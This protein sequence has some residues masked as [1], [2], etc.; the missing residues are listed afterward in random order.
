MIG[1]SG[2]DWSDEVLRTV[3]WTAGTFAITAVVFLCVVALLIRF[4]G[5]GRQFWRISGR[6][7]TGPS[8]W[9]AWGLLAANMVTAIFSVR[10]QLLLTYQGNDMYTAM[11]HVFQALADHRPEM[12]A[13]SETQ[14]WKSMVV[15]AVLATVLVLQQLL[16]IWV[17]QLFQVNW[18][19]WLTDLMAGDWLTDRAFYRNRFIDSTID[20][21]DQRIQQD[22]SEFVSGSHGLAFGGSVGGNSIGSGGAVGAGVALATFAP[23]LWD[24]SA[25]LTVLGVTIPRALF[26]LAF[27]FILFGTVVAFRVG[28]PLTQ[29][30]FALQRRTADFRY[31]LV[32]L[33]DNAESIAFY[34]GEQT[35]RRNLFDRFGAMIRSYWR[36]IYRA[37]TFTGWNLTVSQVAVVF[38]FLLL[39]PLVASGKMTL[40]QITQ[41]SSAFGQVN[42]AIS[43][44]RNSYDAFTY[45][46]STLVRLD[47]LNLADEQS[48]DLPTVDIVPT[49]ADLELR[50]VG[51]AKPDGSALIT[52]LDLRLSPGDA[53]VVK[54]PSGSGKTTLLRSV[55]GLWPFASGT[56]YR[57]VG[58]DVLF[59]SQFPYLPLGDV[60]TA[61]AYPAQPSFDDDALRAVLDTV[62]LAH[63]DDRI[64]DERDWAAILSPGERQRIA[65]ARILLNRPKLVFLDEA[66]SAMDEGLEYALYHL[67]RTETPDTIL[68]SVAHRST[69]DVHHTH[70]LEL[71]GDGAW[72][73]RAL[74][75]AGQP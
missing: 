52:D 67:I 17:T 48:R 75:P 30:N 2:H 66:T 41:A 16:S 72:S 53:L 35:E 38:P 65:F 4:T 25:P 50:G 7:F 60:R 29:L 59:L 23:L 37:I 57:P 19:A 11:Q 31:S 55:A 6:Y 5:W 27:G 3:R 58:D 63:L 24:L 40:G 14:F 47:G 1:A 18:W 10:V 28:R 42:G 68:V 33:R 54:G 43:M 39:F 70:L 71:T 34:G 74:A 12:L 51:V 45:W 49:P 36:L 26:W 62:H 44:P 15:F 22:I 61:V 8:R 9:A 20:N 21:P 13:R 56:V 69:V 64:D 32:R 73:L 46:R